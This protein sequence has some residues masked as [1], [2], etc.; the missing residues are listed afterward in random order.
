MVILGEI[1]M[2]KDT[3]YIR[4]IIHLG[5]VCSYW[6]TPHAALGGD[7][8]RSTLPLRQRN[9]GAGNQTAMAVTMRIALF[10]LPAERL[11]VAD[12]LVAQGARIARL[13]ASY[14]REL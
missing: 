6:C 1:L 9:S 3:H 4:Q 11:A 14:D 7:H 5:L 2:L 10:S 13:Y 12:A 8:D